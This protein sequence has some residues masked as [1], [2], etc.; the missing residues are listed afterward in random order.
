MGIEKIKYKIL[1]NF[2]KKKKKLLWTLINNLLTGSISAPTISVLTLSEDTILGKKKEKI[3]VT[4]DSYQTWYIINYKNLQE[5]IIKKIQSLIKKDQKYNFIDVGANTGLLTKGI[6]NKIEH[7]ENCY[8]VEPGEDNF[9]CIKN[10]LKNYKNVHSSNF[11]LDTHD[12]EKKLFID[13]NNK[14][15]LSFNYEMMSLEEDKLNFL[16]DK[17]DFIIT[18]C[19]KTENFFNEIRNDLKNIIKIDVQGHDEVVFQEIPIE[20]LKKTLILIIEI[21]PLITKKI[22]FVKFSRNLDCFKK[23]TDFKGKEYSKDDVINLVKR[24]KGK[25]FDLVFLN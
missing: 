19:K 20:T 9:F 6:L 4:K 12:G 18:N 2:F 17:N 25:S 10:N 13:K 15:N 3:F 14:G 21:T 16:N 24:M 5:C 11:A 23:F 7:I 1:F 22:D 8:L